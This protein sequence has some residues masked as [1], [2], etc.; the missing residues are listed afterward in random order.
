MKRT[1]IKRKVVRWKCWVRT[2]SPM[3]TMYIHIYIIY[4]VFFIY[5][6]MIYTRK[7]N[8]G[9]NTRI[10]RTCLKFLNIFGCLF[11]FVLPAQVFFPPPPQLRREHYTV[12][13]FTPFT[14]LLYL[15][16]FHGVVFFFLFSFFL[17]QLFILLRT[18]VLYKCA[19]NRVSEGKKKSWVRSTPS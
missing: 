7:G 4:Y 12:L 17:Q 19:H 5:I 13:S 3:C 15:I 16:F 18:S 11:S 14:Y 2:V 10:S 8:Y 6:Y 1:G 9:P